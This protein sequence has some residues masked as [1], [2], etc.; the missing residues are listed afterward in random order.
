VQHIVSNLEEHVNPFEESDD[1]IHLTSG[2]VASQNVADDLL[3]AEQMGMAALENFTDKRLNSNAEEFHAP[4]KKLQL[5]TFGSMQFN[6]SKSSRKHPQNPTET[7]LPV[8][9]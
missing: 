4:L 9:W 2:L 5:K 7:C 8:C 3:G 1:L 6:D